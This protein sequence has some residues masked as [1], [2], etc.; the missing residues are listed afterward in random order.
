MHVV[1]VHVGAVLDSLGTV[2]VSTLGS[3]SWSTCESL[4]LWRIFKLSDGVS[5]ERSSVFPCLRPT[6]SIIDASSAPCT[7]FK[8]SDTHST[9]HVLPSATAQHKRGKKIGAQ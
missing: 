2:C 3:S 1:S 4:L 9:T 6:M 7:P 5:G 8:G